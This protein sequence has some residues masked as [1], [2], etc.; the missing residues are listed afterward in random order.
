MK[1]T[2]LPMLLALL[3]ANC[4]N[5]KKDSQAISG[6]Y[7]RISDNELNILYDTVHFSLI[8]EQAKNVYSISQRSSSH[9][10]K[11]KDQSFNKRNSRI[12]TGNYDDE[13]KVMRTEDPGIAYSFDFADGTATI[14]G[15]VYRKIK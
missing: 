9:F 1:P 5:S 2:I 6:T 11:E 12:I 8:N 13:N 3:I 10:K 14:N 7:I 4:N 15:I